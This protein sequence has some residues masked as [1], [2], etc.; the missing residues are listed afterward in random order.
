MKKSYTLLVLSYFI[1]FYVSAQSSAPGSV[2]A[3]GS[4]LERDM[5]LRW[6][7]NA[8]N[9]NRARGTKLDLNDIEGSVY[10]NDQFVKG[11]VF[12]LDKLF[13]SYPMRYNAYSDE[14]EIRRTEAS[15]LESVYKSTSLTC[16][17]DNE[18]YIYAKYFDNNGE[19]KEGYIIRLN[20]GPKYVLF[21]KKS[22]VYKEGKKATTSMHP[23]YPPKFED[24]H[25]YYIST[26]GEYPI[27]FK[28]SKKELT[29]IFGS[30]MASELKSFIKE[31]KIKLNNEQDLIK[32]MDF[33]NS[34]A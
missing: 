11:D 3:Q 34:N 4:P 24:K 33:V 26:D 18:R 6:L 30:D 22:K 25:N 9:M 5:A 13:D 31:N 1:A 21:E 20:E 27:H 15:A 14:I 8:N 16:I 10:Y 2:R 28:G 19:V 29:A 17:I 23:T 7:N 12:Y 32:L